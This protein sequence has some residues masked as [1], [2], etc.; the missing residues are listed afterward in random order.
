MFILNVIKFSFLI[1][2]GVQARASEVFYAFPPGIM[3]KMNAVAAAKGDVS[4][5]KAVICNGAQPK[6]RP[7]AEFTVKYPDT[8]GMIIDEAAKE[9]QEK[10]QSIRKYLKEQYFAGISY[11]EGVSD[12]LPAHKDQEVFAEA[13]GEP[14]YASDLGIFRATYTF[15]IPT[16]VLEGVF[17][18]HGPGDKKYFGYEYHAGNWK[19]SLA[20]HYRDSMW[21]RLM[22][23][24]TIVKEAP[25]GDSVKFQIE[26]D[27]SIFCA[28]GIS[29]S[30]LL[31]K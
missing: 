10:M 7:K 12:V 21:R 23:S 13:F 20:I 16:E 30:D 5:L 25:S 4:Y 22:A 31:S 11:V 27:L 2:L 6:F 14:S 19:A 18:A 15:K 28:Y 24:Q 9:K 17:K 3:Q 29:A 1:L 8:A 26:L